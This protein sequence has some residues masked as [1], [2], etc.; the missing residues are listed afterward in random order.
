MIEEKEYYKKMKI[1][2]FCKKQ[3]LKINTENPR[4][5]WQHFDID[6]RIK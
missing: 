1:K 2:A 6:D 4:I 3:S 5:N